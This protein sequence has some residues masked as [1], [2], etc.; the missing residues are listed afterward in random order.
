MSTSVLKISYMFAILQHP[1]DERTSYFSQAAE[2]PWQQKYK[3]TTS[4]QL[5][6]SF[7][8]LTS[9]H[10]IYTRLLYDHRSTVEADFYTELL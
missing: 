8:Y 2:L 9:Y 1:S 4:H 3:K 6:P 10:F 7:I 5:L